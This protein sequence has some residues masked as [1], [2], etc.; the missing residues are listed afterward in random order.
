MLTDFPIED[1]SS[2][3]VCEGPPVIRE[4]VEL[5]LDWILAGNLRPAPIDHADNVPG[6]RQL[7]H[8]VERWAREYV[9]NGAFILACHEAGIA[10]RRSPSFRAN[11]DVAARPTTRAKFNDAF[12]LNPCSFVDPFARAF[13]DAEER[14]S[15]KAHRAPADIGPT[16]DGHASLKKFPLGES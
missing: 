1:V 5:C 14:S 15:A 13:V 11:T 2:R 8:M 6:S 7:K 10:Q 12:Y 9:S 16:K 4:Q 3:G